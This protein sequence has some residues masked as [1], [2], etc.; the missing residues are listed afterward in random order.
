MLSESLVQQII[1]FHGEQFTVVSFYLNVDAGQNQ[2]LSAYKIAAKDLIKEI[3]TWIKNHE[4]ILNREQLNSLNEDIEKIQTII[5]KISLP[6]MAQGYALFSCSG[7]GFWQ[8][9][10]LPLP[11]KNMVMIGTNPFVRP[12]SNILDQYK[13]YGLC[14]VDRSRMLVAE[15]LPNEVTALEEMTEPV[16]KKVRYGGW[17]GYAESHIQR[18][19]EEHIYLH[20]KHSATFAT[21]FYKN[22]TIERLIII[23]PPPV[24]SHFEELLPDVLRRKIIARFPL[25]IF[26]NNKKELVNIVRKINDSLKEE[27]EQSL[28]EKIITERDWKCCVRSG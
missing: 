23:A 21:E 9:V 4:E 25:D 1:R 22:R 13:R 2:P 10:F 3:R 6:I 19:V 15:V 27:E 16:P 28:V 12:L 8:E 18:H 14:M 26:T 24:L 11:V 5:N 20:L 7:K 17:Q